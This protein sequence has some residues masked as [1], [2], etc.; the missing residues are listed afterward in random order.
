MTNNRTYHLDLAAGILML[1]IIT[2]HAVNGA[3]VFGPVDARVAIPYLTFAMPW[4]FT[5]PGLFLTP[6]GLKMVSAGM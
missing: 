4:F 5:N 2:F 3:K 6:Q 1:W